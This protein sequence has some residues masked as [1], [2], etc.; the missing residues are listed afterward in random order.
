MNSLIDLTN[1]AFGRLKVIERGPNK[2]RHTRWVCKCNCGRTVLV[3]S[4]H[5]RDGRVRSCGCIRREN[6]RRLGIENPPISFRYEDPVIPAFNHVLH[7]YIVNAKSRKL[8][9]DLPR[10]VAIRLFSSNCHY[11]GRPPALPTRKVR[12][13]YNGIDRLNNKVGYIIG[14]VVTA[15]SVCN[16]AKGQ[17]TYNEFIAWINNLVN[18]RTMRGLLELKKEDVSMEP[19]CANGTCSL[20]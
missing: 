9:W 6:S 7:T 18:Y 20:V 5:L 11:C 16:R 13:L 17:L 3:V 15:C 19:A 2:G 10:D 12:I 4:D 1:V 8:V 14:N